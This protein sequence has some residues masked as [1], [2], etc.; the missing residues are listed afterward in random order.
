MAEVESHRTPGPLVLDAQASENWRKFIMQFEIYLVAKGKDEKPDKLKVNLLLNCAGADAIE[1]YSHFVFNEG[2]SNESYEDV[3]RKFKEHCQG[4]RN[5]IYER[6]VFNQRNQK[7]GER[8]DN[9]VSALKRLSL[10]CEFGTLRDSLI[11]D[12]IV[13]GVLSNELRGE[14]LKK[15]DLTLQS[16]HDYCRT[17]EAAELQKFKFASPTG[18][19]QPLSVHPVQGKERAPNPTCKFCGF[20]HRFTKPS[21]CPALRKKCRNCQQEGHFA[22]LCPLKGKKETP[23]ST[24]EQENQ[25]ESMGQGDRGGDPHLYFGS[26]ELGTVSSP[27]STKKSV[28]TLRIAQKEVKVKADTGAEANVMP[29]HVYKAITTQPLRKIHQPLKG[30]L[31]DKAIHPVGCVRLPT[32]YKNR[33]IDLLYLVV[34]GEFTPLLSCEAC[35]DLEVLKFMNLDLIDTPERLAEETTQGNG[36]KPNAELLVEDPVLSQYQ[37]CFS[38]KP[39]RLPNKVH[40]EID[41]SVPAVVHPPRKIPISLLEPTREK[42]QEMEQDGIIVKEE[43]HTPWVSSMLVVDKRKEKDRANPPSKDSV[44]ICIDPRDLNKALKRPHY[45]MVTVEQVANRLSGATMFTTLDACSGYWQV[46]VDEESSKLL[47]FNTPWGRYRFTRLPFGIS[48]APEIYQREMDRLF[49][50]VAV[51]IIVDDFLIHGKDISD[52]DRKMIAVLERSR[53][54][55]LKFNPKKIKLRVPEVSYVGHVFTSEGLKPDPEKVRAI[56]EMPPPSDKDGMQRFL[57]TINYLDKFIEH[58]ADLQ[59]PISQLTQQVAAFTWEKPQQEAFEKLKAVITHAP[60]LAY[61][62]NHKQTILNVDASSTGLGA[63][64][65]QE[66][67]PIAFGSKTLSSCEQRYANIERELLAILWGA[68]KFHTYVYGRRVIVETD[69]KPLE[70]IFRK[71]LNECPPRLQRMLL[72]LTKYDLDV[73][74]VPGKKQ[75]ISDCLSRAPLTDTTPVS[76]P[77]DV[78]GI[79]LIENLGIENSTLK[80]FRDAS[81]NDETSRVVMEYVLEGWPEDKDQVDE[82]AREYWNYKEELSV[83]D[84]LLFKSDRIVVPRSM[85]AEVLEDI[86]GAHMGESKSLSLARDYV[87]WPSMTAHIKDRVRSCQICNAF[88]NQQQRE[89]LHPHDLPSLPWQVVGTDLFEFAGHSYLIVVDFYSK[90]FE[91]EL[92]RQSTAMC[93][94]NTLKQIFAR[95]GIPAK[96]ISDNGP[97]YSNTRN[98]FSTTHEFKQF[99]EAWG[100]QHVTSSPEYPQSNGAAERAVQTAKRIFKKAAAENKD[101]FEGLLKYRNTPFDDIGVSPAQLLMSRRTRSTLPTHRRLLVPHPVDPHRVVKALAHR[102]ASSR[103]SYDQHSRDLPPLEVG[104]K[105]RVR[106]NKDKEWC[107][108]EVLPRSYVVEDEKGRVF[109]RNRRHIISVPKDTPMNPKMPV[110]PT[111]MSPQPQVV[112]RKAQINEP[113]SPLKV[114]EDQRE[115]EAHSPI[116]TRAGREVK[117]PQRL[118]EQC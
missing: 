84:G 63:V 115:T 96:V 73:R 58:K 25:V 42:L 61:F 102:Q 118:I 107:K 108:A 7:E 90:Y 37:D 34:H 94:V 77:E 30:W 4:A 39:G 5:V 86:H 27:N 82:L 66:G 48:S 62:D 57:G 32:Q 2:E 103:M 70:A 65:I 110:A 11:R 28:I 68:D 20:Q 15:P 49:A 75:I 106:V 3:C 67:K 36:N 81:S 93:V 85:R 10:T 80:K 51:E 44:R 21:I 33:K 60:V 40:L 41:P 71:P 83:E 16:A 78:I 13:G 99:A 55:G 87:F 97:Q 54:V 22:K 47:T 9:F 104:D 50:G 6:L 14:L 53:E 23:V 29:Y 100:F 98:I 12:R 69:H 116:R 91:V 88:R 101:P 59:G 46:E 74:Y 111:Y 109:R 52:V 56:S 19:Q 1:E 113:P 105:V 72:K 35:L 64:I 45:P 117:K 89:T 79:N 112:A 8:M 38:N 92:L 24:V 95:F 26:V 76:E 114:Q 17:Y 18:S 43:E 31:A